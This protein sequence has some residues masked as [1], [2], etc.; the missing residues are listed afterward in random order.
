MNRC[1]FESFVLDNYNACAD[2][3]WY[4]YPNYAQPHHRYGFRR[5][6]R[7]GAVG[8]CAGAEDHVPGQAAG[9]AASRQA[10]TAA[11]RGGGRDGRR[12][13]RRPSAQFR[14]RGSFDG[15]GNLRGEGRLGHHAAGRLVRLDRHGRHVG[16]F[17]LPQYPAFRAVPADDQLR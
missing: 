2:F 12:H 3:P 1:E 14:Q 8:A 5:P 15:L 10:V 11:R 17:A 6:E 16:A 7:R 13:E 9:Q 4:I